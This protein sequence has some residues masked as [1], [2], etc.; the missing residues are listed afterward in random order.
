MSFYQINKSSNK[1]VIKTVNELFVN[2][3]SVLF[4]I[5]LETL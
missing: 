4:Q 5:E 1:S 3:M 2:I